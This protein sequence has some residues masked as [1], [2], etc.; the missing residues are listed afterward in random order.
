MDAMREDIAVVEVITQN[1]SFGM[2][3]I[4]NYELRTGIWSLCLFPMV[5][6]RMT[7]EIIREVPWAVCGR[8]CDL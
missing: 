3:R 4:Y 5:M 1:G 6:D 2:P 7:C 8:R